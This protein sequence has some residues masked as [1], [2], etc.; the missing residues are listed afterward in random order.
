MVLSLK[1]YLPFPE[2][3]LSSRRERQGSTP[4]TELIQPRSMF[5]G[6]KCSQKRLQH[7]DINLVLILVHLES[8][9]LLQAVIIKGFKA[10]VFYASLSFS[11]SVRLFVLGVKPQRLSS[12]L[13]QNIEAFFDITCF[14]TQTDNIAAN[15]I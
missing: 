6:L 14:Q 10:D 2:H 7:V 4:I 1:V 11:Q 3:H 8:C 9:G 13:G 12:F 5:L 15:L